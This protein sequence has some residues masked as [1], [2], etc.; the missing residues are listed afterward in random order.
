MRPLEIDQLIA[1]AA[2]TSGRAPPKSSSGQRRLMICAK[3]IAQVLACIGR[4]CEP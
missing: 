3:R 2:Q 4:I 1:V